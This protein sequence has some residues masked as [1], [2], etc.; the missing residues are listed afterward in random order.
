MDLSDHSELGGG[1]EHQLLIPLGDLYKNANGAIER[2]L[3]YCVD[4]VCSYALQDRDPKAIDEVSTLFHMYLD[5][6]VENECEET[7]IALTEAMVEELVSN[8]G[9]TFAWQLYQA[10]YPYLAPILKK[11]EWWIYTLDNLTVINNNLLV[12]LDLDSDEDEPG[13]QSVLPPTHTT[14]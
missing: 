6:L 14:I 12:K 8:N 3:Y 1:M 13:I 11:A 2:N 9:F 10:M 5:M 7:D 4:F